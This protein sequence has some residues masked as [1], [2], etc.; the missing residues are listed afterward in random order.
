VAVAV[1]YLL[2]EAVVRVLPTCCWILAKHCTSFQVAAAAAAVDTVDVAAVAAVDT[3]DV[4]AV[5]AEED[6]QMADVAYLSGIVEQTT[7]H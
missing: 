3:V 5:V 6:R 2:L 7:F 4:A 1:A